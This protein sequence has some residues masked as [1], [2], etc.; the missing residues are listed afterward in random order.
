MST[1]LQ[2]VQGEKS[3]SLFTTGLKAAQLEDTISGV[4]PFTILAPVNLAFGKLASP[5]TFESMVKQT[6]TNSKLSD[7]L[8]F[9]I[10]KGKKTI[11][12]FRDGQK[13]QTVSGLELLVSVR[14]G[15]VKINGAKILA[16]D[17]QGSNGVIHTVDAVNQPQKVVAPL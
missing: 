3:L 2:L 7:L 1:I 10:I 16:K 6:S 5:D 15:E 8:N 11:R 13:L 14:D 17:K 4:G 12:D 9:H